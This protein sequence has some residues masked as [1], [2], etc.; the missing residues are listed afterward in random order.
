MKSSTR[1]GKQVCRS[2]PWTMVLKLRGRVTRFALLT[3]LFACPLGPLSRAQQKPLPRETEEPTDVARRRQEWFHKQRAF[4]LKH[5]PAGA[6]ARALEHLA[7]MRMREAAQHTSGDIPNAPGAPPN[8]PNPAWVALG[9]Q[10]TNS[11]FFTPFT[12]GR[13]TALAVDR[14]DSTGKTVYLGGAEGGVW[15]TTDG[16]MNWTPLTDFQPSL[17]TGSIALDTSLCMGT[18]AH[19][20]AIYVGTG[21]EDFSV[22]SYYG[23]GVL[24][25]TDGG[26]TWT[27]FGAS[28]FTGT[29]VPQTPGGPR[30][31]AIAIDPANTSILLAA[32]DGFQTGFDEGLWRSTNGGSTWVHVLPTTPFNNIVATDVVFDPADASGKTAYAALGSLGGTGKNGVYKSADSGATWTMLSIAGLA[33]TLF[34]RISLAVGPPASGSGPGVLFASIADASG[35]STDLLG[36]FKSTNGGT[37]WTRLL[38][39]VVQSAG[40]FCNF[41]CWYDMAIRVSPTNPSV[42]FLGGAAGGSTVSTVFRST[43]GGTTWANVS[44][45]GAGSNLHVDTH[46]FAFTPDGKTLFVGDDGGVWSSADVASPATPAGSQHWTNLNATLNITQFYPGHSVHPSN[47]RISIGGTQD[48]GL[49]KHED[50]LAA[51]SPDLSWSDLG[52]A[53]DGGFTAVDPQIPS[54]VYGTCEYIPDGLLIIGVSFVG[55]DLSGQNGILIISGIDPSD[56]GAFIPPLVIDSSNPQRLYFGTFR[57]WQTTNGGN[58]WLPISGGLSLGNGVLTTIAVAPTD[59]NTI[60]AGSDDGTVW[61]TTNGGAIWNL[62]A[63]PFVSPIPDRA[64]TAV[65]VDPH[66]STTAYVTYSGFSGVFGSDTTGHVFKTINGGTSW[67]DISCTAANCGTPNPTDLPNTPINDLV[68]DPDIANTLY[69][70]TDIGVFQTSNGGAT[71]STLGAGSLPNV[72][73]LSLKLQEPAR[74]LRAATHGRGVWDLALGNQA[75]FGLTGISPVLA[76]AGDPGTTLTVD[77]NG[78]TASSQVRWNGSPRTTAFVSSSRLTA[79]ITMN[80]FLSGAAAPVSVSDPGH[81]NPT[82]PLVFTVLSPV[83]GLA[84]ISPPAVMAGANGVALMLTGSNFAGSTV[85]LL[86][87]AAVPTTFVNSTT[88]TANIPASDL[89]VAQLATIDVFA[90]PPGGGF[91]N[92]PQ[93][94]AIN[95]PVPAVASLSPTTANGG[96]SGFALMVTGSN[97]NSSSVVNWNGTAR[98]TT[99]GSSTQLT[100]AI[101]SGDLLAAGSFPVTVSNPAPGGGNSNLMNVTVNAV[102]FTFGNPSPPSQTVTAGIRADYSVPISSLGPVGTGVALSCSNLPGGGTCSISPNPVFPVA[103]GTN[104]AVSIFTVPRT[105]VP[106]YRTGWGKPTQSAAF[107]P[108]FV[109]AILLV[110]FWMFRSAPRPA[111]LA[112]GLIFVILSL[113][114]ALA[115]CGGGG[116]GGGGGG[117]PPGTYMVTITGMSGSLQHSATVTIIVK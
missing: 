112:T 86:N 58:S 31:G 15:K 42:I 28:A 1:E 93:T 69:V 80:D 47:P 30:I 8:S 60:Y 20:N 18:P 104:A 21:E 33:P 16:G 56:P 49:Q 90:P 68:V 116:G 105:S 2:F 91:D 64:V 113:T 99:F 117:T 107:L 37:T 9:P 100:A 87:G 106:A 114:F 101:L 10:P 96:G 103:G 34:G 82:A 54:T 48:N 97:F 13:T 61:V 84:S 11:P 71:W 26:S 62:I 45:S 43:D 23:A 46:A 85:A 102:D 50:D 88:L 115:N 52:V 4:P 57:V 94:L 78:F 3:L 14:C 75:A 92:N 27:V 66:V 12:S 110:L 5:I 76:H 36:V 44:A 72:V 74:A 51:A 17:A 98:Q 24:K 39:P 19:A 25:S 108:A 35:F 29:T 109:L 73:V 38:A 40:G 7:A 95:N 79:S 70:A 63:R 83:P 22:D 89:A 32:V 67:T 111:R 81:A 41:Q 65:S 77:G 53:C 55:G 6:R 59:S